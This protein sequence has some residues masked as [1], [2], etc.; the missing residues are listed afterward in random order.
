MLIN[1]IF[2][3][4]YWKLFELLNSFGASCNDHIILDLIVWGP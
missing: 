3:G 4:S 1:V 2:G